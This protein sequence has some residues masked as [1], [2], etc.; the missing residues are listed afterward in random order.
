MQV[1][2]TFLQV[3]FSIVSHGQGQMIKHLLTDIDAMY[4][5]PSEIIITLNLP[6]NEHFIDEYRHLN[7]R[8]IRNLSPKGFGE[9]HN[10][11]CKLSTTNFFTII[12]PDIRLIP[13]FKISLMINFLG[14]SRIAAIGPAVYAS[15]GTL[16]DSARFFPTVIN[17]L[18]RKIFSG[19]SNDY[20]LSTFPLPVDWLA[21][22]FIIFNK[23]Y[24]NQL[25]GFDE[26]YFMYCEDVDICKRFKEA[27]YLVILD[28]RVSVIHD[29]QRESRRNFKYLFW[30][31]KSLC[32]Y[33][34][35]S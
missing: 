6:E 26:N 23:S 24:F 1:P 19:K 21:G 31:V 27:N 13:N 3:T 20:K 2:Q 32:R 35:L 12:N 22:M 10:F 9:N 5:K 15:N 4:E 14:D 34:F 8:I 28:S 11:A 18:R 7:L 16:E 30:H 33:L 17:L 29:A 25:G